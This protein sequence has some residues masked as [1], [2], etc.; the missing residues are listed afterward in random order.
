MPLF[1]SRSFD[2]ETTIHAAIDVVRDAIST[3]EKLS[4]LHPFVI[5]VEPVSLQPNTYEIIDRLHFFGIPYRLRYRTRML[6]SPEGIDSEVWAPLQFHHL[7]QIR[8]SSVPEGTL[9]REHVAM[10]A[11]W[12]LANYALRNAEQAHR[13]MLSRLKQ[14]VETR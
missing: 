7:G 14:R 12:P 8:L 11:P 6:F 2:I 5:S 1:V 3:P 10:Q 13:E 9:V 4:R